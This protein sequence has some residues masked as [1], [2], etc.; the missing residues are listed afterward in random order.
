MEEY[1]IRTRTSSVGA[2]CA[3][4]VIASN[5]ISLVTTG[6]GLRNLFLKKKRF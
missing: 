3:L 5:L 1:D 6:I 2:A 4:V